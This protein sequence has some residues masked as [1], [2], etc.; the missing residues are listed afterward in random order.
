MGPFLI[1]GWAHVRVYG[2]FSSG[3]YRGGGV[4]HVVTS[5]HDVGCV[6]AEMNY[7][8]TGHAPK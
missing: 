6:I 2:F 3:L 1:E 8:V 5:R 4:G 7:G